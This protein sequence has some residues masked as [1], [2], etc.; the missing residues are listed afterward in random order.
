MERLTEGGRENQDWGAAEMNQKRNRQLDRVIE[1]WMDGWMA[2]QTVNRRE[3][4]KG[5]RGMESHMEEKVVEKKDVYV[6]RGMEKEKEE[7]EAY[8]KTRN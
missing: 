1:R 5:K 8:C 2:R 6:N 4:S 3:G 7:W